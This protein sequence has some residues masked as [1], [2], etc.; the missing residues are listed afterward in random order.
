ML[1]ADSLPTELQGKPRGP[2][3]SGLAQRGEQDPASEVDSLDAFLDR[4]ALGKDGFCCRGHTT[5]RSDLEGDQIALEFRTSLQNWDLNDSHRL[6]RTSR[7]NRR[8]EQSGRVLSAL[9]ALLLMLFRRPL[10]SDSLQPRGL[11]HTRPPCPSPS[12]RVCPS[13]HSLHHGCH[14]A[15]SSSDQNTGAS[16]SGSVL[17][18]NIQGCSPLRLTG[19]YAAV[20]VLIT[21]VTR[22]KYSPAVEML[23]CHNKI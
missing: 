12:P 18:V 14:P 1:Q 16:A 19:Y 9:S 13:S 5:P 23:K 21:L 7:S 20:P 3:L 6:D 17:P 2:Q 22:I 4:K 11:Q 10:T 15:I 8:C